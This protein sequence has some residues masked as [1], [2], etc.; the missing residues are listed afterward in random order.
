MNFMWVNSFEIFSCCKENSHLQEKEKVLID[1]KC[2]SFLGF[3]NDKK[4]KFDFKV[5]FLQLHVLCLTFW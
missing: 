5:C 1:I 3:E 4:T 2:Q